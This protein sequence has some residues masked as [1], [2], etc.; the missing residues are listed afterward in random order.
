ML[1]QTEENLVDMMRNRRASGC[2]S[3]GEGGG[4]VWLG[5]KEGSRA[6]PFV[7]CRCESAG[8]KRGMVASD[9]SVVRARVSV[10][11]MESGGCIAK[12]LMMLLEIWFG[13][14]GF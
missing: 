1:L 12:V 14:D 7:R 4:D 13:E 5:V 3:M 10:T 9:E 8:E 11:W 2:E 6:Y